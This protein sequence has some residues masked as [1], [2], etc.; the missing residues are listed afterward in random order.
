MLTA[1]IVCGVDPD[2]LVPTFAAL[3]E[4]SVA[5]LLADVIVVHPE[6]DAIASV[7]EPTGATAVRVEGAT[8]AL[9]DARG[10]WVL[11]LEAGSRPDGD[12]V[13]GVAAHIASPA[14]RNG[15]FEVAGGG[16]PFWRRLVGRAHRP[17]RSGLVIEREAAISALRTTTPARLPVGRAAVT[18]R[19]RLL[20]TA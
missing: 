17:L 13:P 2:P 6:P 1:L 10:D 15:R 5:G 20:P 7:C 16:E 12:W 9:L 18:M 8:E 3:V 19:A 14:G 11:V 4:A